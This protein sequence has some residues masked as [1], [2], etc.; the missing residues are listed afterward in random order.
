MQGTVY[1]SRDTFCSG[2]SG[3]NYFFQNNLFT[4]TNISELVESV[5]HYY[6]T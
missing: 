5:L 6:K 4:V 1:A 3:D 2:L